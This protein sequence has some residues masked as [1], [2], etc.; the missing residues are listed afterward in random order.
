MAHTDWI[1][2]AET[3]D[4]EIVNIVDGKD[5]RPGG[6][7]GVAKRAPR[8]GEAM[9]DFPE[10]CPSDVDR[11]VRSAMAAFEE[12]RWRLLSATDRKAVLLRLADLIDRNRDEFALYE[13]L[14]VGKPISLS[15]AE[16]VGG[17]VAQ[18][19]DTAEKADKII[20]PA[21]QDGRHSA[22][23][24]RKPV[25]VIGAIVGWNYPLSLAIGKIAP[26]LAMGNSVI[27][28]PS[29]FTPLSATLLAKLALEA[30]VPP[31]V[32][33]LVH[34]RGDI[35]GAALCAHPHVDLISFTGSTR[36]GRRIMAAAGASNLKRVVLECG[37]K[38]P[39]LVF[40]DCLPDLD[41]LAAT[42]VAVAFP[43][44]G[45][46]C[47]AATRLLVHDDL[48][49]DLVS[50]VVEYA[51]RIVPGDPL[52]PA[53]AYGAIIHEAH[54]S[55]VLAAI[56]SGQDAGARLRLGGRRHRFDEGSELSGGCYLR[57]TVFDDVTSDMAI[58]R[59]EIFGPVLTVQ[60]FRSDD[61]AVA[62][63]NDTDFGL[64]AYAAT[65]DLA[66]SQRLARDIRA[67]GLMIWGT[68]A[69]RFGSIPLG[70]EPHKQSGFGYETGFEALLGC[71][72][73]TA[74]HVMS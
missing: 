12:G 45:A 9:Y 64:S 1:R 41:T 68:A 2:R 32:F 31:G 61:E 25:G 43:N 34:G 49:Q 54:L 46:R 33:N 30:G 18:L 13:T 44:Q 48:K 24:Q 26:A 52:D 14:D 57:P 10:G 17:S 42:I 4:F 28:K 53:T 73:A 23:I 51:R 72:V 11:A 63:A 59:E 67:G 37:G 15:L 6:S 66:R 39:F 16:D 27:L 58:A 21:A 20:S 60:S 74:V 40:Q 3:A 38:S 35:I 7:G 70:S 22:F 8:T 65:R 47:T 29:E 69:P 71:S 36:T 62:L 55:A 56:K 50:R 19:R 5:V